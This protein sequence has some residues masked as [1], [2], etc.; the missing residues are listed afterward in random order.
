MIEFPI[1]NGRVR[2][3]GDLDGV[4]K[5]GNVDVLVELND[6]RRFGPTFFTIENLRSLMERG[7]VTGECAGGLYVWAS[8]MIVVEVLSVDVIQRSIEALIEA[9]ELDRACAPLASSRD[10]AGE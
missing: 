8:D 6:G 4:V 2:V 5:D 1:S 3:R 9:E 7:S 10:R